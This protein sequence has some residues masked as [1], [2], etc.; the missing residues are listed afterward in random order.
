MIIITVFPIAAIV[1]VQTHLEYSEYI[2]ISSK[3]SLQTKINKLTN[4]RGW[5]LNSNITDS[6]LYESI[7]ILM[8]QHLIS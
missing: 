4:V 8:I 3:I 5:T 7:D 1:F 2:Y 6:T